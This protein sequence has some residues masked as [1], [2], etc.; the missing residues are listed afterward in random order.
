M[1]AVSA[2][3]LRSASG[4]VLYRAFDQLRRNNRSVWTYAP[5]PEMRLITLLRMERELHRRGVRGLGFVL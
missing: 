2:D 3:P 4:R 5:T 1:R